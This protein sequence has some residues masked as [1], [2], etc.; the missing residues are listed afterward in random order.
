M[1]KEQWFR[2]FERNIAESG[3]LD[4]GDDAAYEQAAEDATE[5]LLDAEDFRRKLAKEQP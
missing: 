4:T 1:S 3:W 5:D 2:A